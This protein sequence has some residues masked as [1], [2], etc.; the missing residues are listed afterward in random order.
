MK[1][2]YSAGRGTKIHISIDGEYRFTTDLDFWF[3]LG[4]NNNSEISDDELYSLEEK[5]KVRKAYNK[6]ID[7]LSLRM[8]SK[9]ELLNKI[10]KTSEEKYA[11]IAVNLLEEKGYADDEEFAREY[12]EYLKRTKHMANKRIGY[13]LSLKGIDRATIYA[14]EVENGEDTAAE[15]EA[16]LEGK[17]RRSLGDEKSRKKVFNALVRLGYSY[18][19]ARGALDKYKFDG[20]E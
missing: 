4:I 6:G 5:I 14:L 20:E 18:S 11:I 12:W 3:T 1:L 13:E 2:T 10:K 15:I 9:K 19:D 8:N 16:L 17:F 7:L